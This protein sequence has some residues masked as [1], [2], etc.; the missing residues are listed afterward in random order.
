MKDSK[1]KLYMKDQLKEL[2]NK[3]SENSSTNHK[4][5]NS[6]YAASDKES[7]FSENSV[8][9]PSAEQPP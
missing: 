1:S 5:R 3:G 6:R 8:V 7:E 4:Q 2:S 9:L